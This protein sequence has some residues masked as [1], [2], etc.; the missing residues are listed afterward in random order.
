MEKV[1]VF[2]SDPQVLFREGIH[3]I[4]SG[5]EDLEVIGETTTNDEAYTLIE[6]NPPGVAVLAMQDKKTGGPEI[7]RRIRRSL[8]SVSVILTMDKKEDDSIFEAIKSSARAC[9]TKDTD[10]EQLL[11]IIRVVSQGSL[12]IATE[13]QSPGVA[14]LALAE[15]EALRELDQQMDNLL[16]HLTAKETQV[17]ESIAAGDS[18]AQTAGKLG[19]SEDAVSRHLRMVLNK[20]VANDQAQAVIEAAQRS[21]PTII[22]R[23]LK[24]DGKAVEYITKAEFNEF[25]DHLMERLKSLL[26]ELS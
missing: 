2:L 14:A 11:D 1:K 23:P 16:A 9:I 22:R 24:K 20:L 7:T 12:L 25:K 6:A 21:L 5:E 13:L 19:A 26:G 18:A 8:P 17:L 4:L 15:F 3:F 10:P